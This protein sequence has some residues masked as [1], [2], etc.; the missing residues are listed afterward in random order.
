MTQ[1]QCEIAS[2]RRS[3][4]PGNVAKVWYGVQAVLL[5]S[6]TEP[7]VIVSPLFRFSELVDQ[8]APLISHGTSH[9][10]RV[11]KGCLAKVW[12]NNVPHLLPAREEHYEYVT[13]YFSTS[14][15]GDWLVDSNA[16]LVVH[17]SIKRIMPSTGEVCVAYE[18]GGLI[19]ISPDPGGKPFITDNE[20]FLVDGFLSTNWNTLVFPSD[21]TKAARRKESSVA[22]DNEV[23]YL[24]FSTRDSLLI[25]IKILLVYQVVDP[26]KIFHLLTRGDIVNHVE[27]LATV[28]MGK[29]I[30]K[31]SS[32]DVMGWVVI[33]S[34]SHLLPVSALV[35][36]VLRRSERAHGKP[37]GRYALLSVCCSPQH[38]SLLC[39]CPLVTVAV[40]SSVLARCFA[41]CCFCRSF[42][43]AYYT[44]ATCCSLSASTCSS[45][46]TSLLLSRRCRSYESR[47]AVSEELA[48]S[49]AP[50]NWFRLLVLSTAVCDSFAS[51][52]RTASV[53]RLPL[54]VWLRPSCRD[55][56]D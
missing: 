8:N 39:V 2:V 16:K 30:Q 6:Q 22:T 9:R 5:E 18:N 17:G 41:R 37:R 20:T 32:Q 44:A 31:S 42:G 36:I 34:P 55:L 46:L 33:I 38:T 14:T 10:V 49:A 11:P 25:G 50:H 26:I 45:R 56:S 54:C 15:A 1:S 12:V 27:N 52:D 51:Q 13:P 43:N 40:F 29:A 7:Y 3:R 24:T 19:V 53:M 47:A 28:D 48:V 4:P 21:E 23:N 35:A